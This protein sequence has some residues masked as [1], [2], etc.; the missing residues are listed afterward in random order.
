M[1]QYAS[2][3]DWL[4]TGRTDTQAF[5]GAIDGMYNANGGGFVIVPPGNFFIQ[6]LV[7]K[8]GVILQCSGQGYGG[9]F[10][11]SQN[12]DVG[13][14]VFDSTCSHAALRDAF[15]CGYT[16]PNAT[17]SNAVSIA[18]NAPVHI[19]NCRIWGGNSALFNN[20]VD[21]QIE[22]C[23]ISG[24]KF[25]S[26]VSN[27]ANWYK[28][29]KFDTSG[30]HCQYG[31]YQGTPLPGGGV[32]ENHFEQCDFSGDYAASIGIY[33][34]GSGTAYS[35]F[36]SCVI[37]SPVLLRQAGHTTFS[38]CA[39][40]SANFSQASGTCSIVACKAYPAMS[41]PGAVKSGNVNIT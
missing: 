30:Q 3:T 34:G 33:D 4:G 9:T 8:G 22:N 23:F 1:S 32:M 29:C 10:L 25:A 37:S 7:M 35:V 17:N 28:R 41:A 39:F 18:V 14:I 40:G 6:N 21:G 11:Q 27:G 24:W 12:E 2:V 20:G 16:N 26:L 38:S 5:Q 31:F 15:V 19:S 13:V 36:N